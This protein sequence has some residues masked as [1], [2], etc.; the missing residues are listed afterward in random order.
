MKVLNQFSTSYGVLHDSDTPMAGDTKNP[1][2]GMNKTILLEKARAAE[3]R[4]RHVACL[5]DFEVALFGKIQKTDKPYNALLKLRENEELQSAVSKLLDSLIS[6][7][8][9][10]ANC[11]RW[12]SIEELEKYVAELA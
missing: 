1:A 2:W 9:P 12:S 10:P 7:T 3:G 5:T 8:E 11:K 6:D 4:V